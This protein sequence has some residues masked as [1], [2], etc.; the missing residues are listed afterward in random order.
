MQIPKITS[1]N[2][3][4]FGSEKSKKQKIVNT[5]A[6]FAIPTVAA[7]SAFLLVDN[8][9]KRKD[10]KN[11]KN[12]ILDQFNKVVEEDTKKHAEKVRSWGEEVT[13]ADL[14]VYRELAERKHIS[15]YK[16][17]M[18]S[19]MQARKSYMKKGII[20]AAGVGISIGALALAIK[21]KPN[22]QATQ[23]QE[24][25]TPSEKQVTLPL[26][27]IAKPN[28]QTFQKPTFGQISFTGIIGEIAD[29][30]DSDTKDTYTRFINGENPKESEITCAKLFAGLKL[31]DWPT[32]LNEHNRYLYGVDDGIPLRSK[33]TTDREY[34][35]ILIDQYFPIPATPPKY[36]RNYD[37][38]LNTET[39]QRYQTWPDYIEKSLI[40]ERMQNLV[41]KEKI[42]I[43]AREKREQELIAQRNIA[44]A[45]FKFKM[46]QE[47]LT[48]FNSNDPN[49]SVKNAIMI[50][51]GT[52]KDRE[53]NLKWLVGKAQNA[54]FVHIKDEQDSNQNLL[55]KVLTAVE[56][57]QENYEKNKH[58]TILWV[59]NFDRLLLDTPDN[60]EIIGDIKAL[61]SEASSEYKTTIIFETDI[62]TR[63]MNP[64]TL[65]EH[66]TKKF[67]I[68]KDSS[69]EV[70]KKLEAE[71]IRSHIKKMKNSD[72]YLFYYKPFSEEKVELYLGK[73][74]Y[75]PNVLWVQS[76]DAEIISTVINNFEVI[77]S[78][79]KFKQVS[80]LH[81]P[82]PFQTKGLDSSKLYYTYE[83]TKDG[84]PIYEYRL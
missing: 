55:N 18:D 69:I 52:K 42:L 30:I 4:N 39:W 59:D 78:I 1:N 83:L 31:K 47:F 51:G 9:T 19:L 50:Q 7:P 20:T 70:L 57:A 75:Q 68:D 36:Y 6:T 27:P 40:N 71:Y 15:T 72:G 10:Y 76:Q 24:Q 77:K 46:N 54:R 35:K 49:V 62:D 23:T 29:E 16:P 5:A 64:I 81:F 48:D 63:K 65:Q 74:G 60:A 26:Q 13:D 84:Q 56:E 67:N 12:S 41:E 53:D 3:Q 17:Q 44:S 8:F 2:F 43:L 73:F 45:C 28:F 38:W 25:T 80:K 14:K 34:H 82:K 22:K 11:A 61:L 79:P 37:K 66:R 33:P 32:Y 21:N 58:R